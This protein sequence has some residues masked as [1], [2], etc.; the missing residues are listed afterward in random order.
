MPLLTDLRRL[1]LYIRLKLHLFPLILALRV[2]LY[3]RNRYL[4]PKSSNYSYLTISGPS[5]RGRLGIYLHAPSPASVTKEPKGPKPVHINVHGGGF[6]LPLHGTDARFCAKMSNEL[7]CYVVDADYRMTPDHPWPAAYNDIQRVLDWVRANENGIFDTSK[8]TIGGFSAG[9]ALVL[10]VVGTANQG[11]LK[12]VV[13]F[14]PPTDFTT[15]YAA[16]PAPP[17]QHLPQSK[18]IIIPVSEGELMRDGYLL[19]LPRP[20]PQDVL[21]D[22]R[23]SPAYAPA[24]KFPD[25]GRTMILSVECDYFGPEGEDFAKK[26]EDAGREPIRVFVEGL[27]HGWDGLCIEGTKEAEVRDE[28]WA[29]AVK[30]IGRAQSDEV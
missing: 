11:V 30:V 2:I 26:L 7:G 12:G 24:E 21:A 17:I 22:P 8:I 13:A 29:R 14:Y 5:G 27:G 18:G 10:A 4:Q 16:K 19:S 25:K 6:C 23:L 3:R 20:Y 1:L 28:M 9:A 15:L